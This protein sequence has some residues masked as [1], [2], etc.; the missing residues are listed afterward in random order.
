MGHQ[1]GTRG[2]KVARKNHVGRPR[3]CSKNSI[4]VVSVFR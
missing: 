3:V 4:N 1:R 2:H